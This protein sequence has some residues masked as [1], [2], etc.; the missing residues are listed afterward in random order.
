MRLARFSSTKIA[1]TLAIAA[2]LAGAPAAFAQQMTQDPSAAPA[3]TYH[4]DK[5]H[6][7]VTMKLSHMGLSYY[8]MR[9]DTIDASY[10]YDPSNPAAS[11]IQVAIDPKSVDTDNPPFN[12]EIA[13]QFFEADKYPAITFVSTAVHP[14]AGGKGEV[15]G[16]LTFH[17]VT[18][19]VVLDVVF[20]GTGQGMM[21][22]QRMGF[23]GVTTVK[24]S[25]FGVTKY[26][27][28]V[29]DDVTVLIEAEFTK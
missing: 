23:S 19:P 12:Q 20:N 7:S 24:R 4:L 1:T 21:H 3:G 27:P 6:A 16:D 5:K 15:V 22:E 17:G 18:R 11:K 26:V 25:D 13:E 14:G 28:L 2:V 9:F 10:T 29:G 8:T